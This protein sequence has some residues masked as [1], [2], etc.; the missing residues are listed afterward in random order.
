[1]KGH[2]QA[3]L[4]L[5]TLLSV[6]G[7]AEEEQWPAEQWPAE[8]A[9]AWSRPAEPEL[10]ARA[11]LAAAACGRRDGPVLDVA[12]LT[13]ILAT[14][15]LVTRLLRDP[16]DAVTWLTRRS[17]LHSGALEHLNSVRV[18]LIRPGTAPWPTPIEI[19]HVLA[20]ARELRKRLNLC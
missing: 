12:D 9:A 13:E 3:A 15:D 2:P 1:M 6:I 17:G 10:T 7:R 11:E 16:F 4:E 14:W 18:T 8:P 5:G 20:T 19:E